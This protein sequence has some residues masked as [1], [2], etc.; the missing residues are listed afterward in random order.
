MTVQSFLFVLIQKFMVA[1]D[2]LKP[3]QTN[4][5]WILL[6]CR[7]AAMKHW[8]SP[9]DTLSN[10][11]M[12][13]RMPTLHR[14]RCLKDLDWKPHDTNI[15]IMFLGFFFKNDTVWVCKGKERLQGAG[16]SYELVLW[17]CKRV[18]PQYTL[19]EV[20]CTNSRRHESDFAR[21]HFKQAGATG[22]DREC[23][24]K[25]PASKPHYLSSTSTSREPRRFKHWHREHFPNWTVNNLTTRLTV[26]ISC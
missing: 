13:T 26:N 23:Q 17:L 16:M 9:C 22:W 25:E 21:K 18:Y 4:L 2:P 1:S 24:G 20:R 15:L 5:Y 11:R 19:T 8:E 3:V 7:I 14:K 6:N 12:K 10:G